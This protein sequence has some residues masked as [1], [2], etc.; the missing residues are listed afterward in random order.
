V[1]ETRH[2][3]GTKMTKLTKITKRNQLVFFVVFVVFVAAAVGP[4]SRERYAA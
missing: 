3:G 1:A 2:G 4:C